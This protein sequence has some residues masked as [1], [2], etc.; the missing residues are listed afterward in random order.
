MSKFPE[1]AQYR[2]SEAFSKRLKHIMYDNDCSSNKEFAELV[3]IS[4]PVIAR[5]EIS[6]L[7]PVREF[8]LKLQISWNCLWR[9]F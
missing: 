2:V 7:F 1:N 8:L 5:A 4:I 6:V 9:I 3:G